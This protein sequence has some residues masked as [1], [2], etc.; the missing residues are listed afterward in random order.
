MSKQKFI[1]TVGLPASGKSHFAEQWVAEDPEN[2]VQVE[3]D[4]I[5]KDARLFKGGEYNHKRGDEAAVVRERNRL[6][7]EAL[8]S[9]KSVISS[10]TNLGGNHIASMSKIAR[11]YGASIE[12]R[13]FL[14]VPIATLLERDSKREGSVGEQVIRR[15]FHQHIKEMPTFYKWVDDR[16]VCVISDIDGTM[17]LGPKDR[18]P[19]E[20]GKVGNDDLNIATSAILDGVQFIGYVEK[21]ILFSGRDESCRKETEEWLAKQCI[22]YDELHMRPAGDVRNDAEIKLELFNKH[23]R[24]KYNVLFVLDD[25]PRV[26]DMWRDVLGLTV[27]QLGDVNYRF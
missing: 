7:S 14:D 26:C 11:E 15:M 8:S 27:L 23:I 2:R 13:E 24:D 9:G 16:E 6:I 18:S 21:T 3:K 12:V 25:R 17:T 10:D 20:W 4:Q 1:I 5:R 19:Y 22:K